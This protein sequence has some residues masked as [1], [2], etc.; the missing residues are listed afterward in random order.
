MREVRGRKIRRF[1]E[2]FAAGIATPNAPLTAALAESWFANRIAPNVRDAV[3]GYSLDD[4]RDKH[5]LPPA[6][7]EKQVSNWLDAFGVAVRCPPR[8]CRRHDL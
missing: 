4:L 5:A 1:L 8:R 2:S 7:W 3:S 6:W